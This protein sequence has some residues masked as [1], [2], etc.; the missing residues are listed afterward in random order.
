[1]EYFGHLRLCH[2][3]LTIERL[4]RTGKRN[5]RGREPG[6]CINSIGSQ[7]VRQ[8][9]SQAHRSKHRRDNQRPNPEMLPATPFRVS[10]LLGQIC[11]QI[12]RRKDVILIDWHYGFV[13]HGFTTFTSTFQRRHS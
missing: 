1:M 5:D 7:F 11:W 13:S 12:V 3:I 2:P 8:P 6:F 10:K 4:S 9:N